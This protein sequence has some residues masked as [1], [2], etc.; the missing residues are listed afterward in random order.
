MLATGNEL[1]FAWTDTGEIPRVLT[2]RL[3]LAGLIGR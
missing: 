1:F 2:A 3:P